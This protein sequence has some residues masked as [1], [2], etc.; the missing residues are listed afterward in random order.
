MLGKVGARRAVD[1]AGCRLMQET[2]SS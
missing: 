1:G 2:L